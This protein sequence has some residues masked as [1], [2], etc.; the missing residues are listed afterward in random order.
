MKMSVA[1]N[2]LLKRQMIS[3]FFRFLLSSI[4]WDVRGCLPRELKH[5]ELKAERRSKEIRRAL[6]H[7]E[8]M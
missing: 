1:T 8:R 2:A 3:E 6:E 5:F 4:D 7:S